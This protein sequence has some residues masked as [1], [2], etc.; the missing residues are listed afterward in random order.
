MSRGPVGGWLLLAMFVSMAW[1]SWS[2]PWESISA[3]DRY[4]AT[5]GGHG[6]TGPNVGEQP[7]ATQL[8]TTTT[9]PAQKTLPE[10]TLWESLLLNL[11]IQRHPQ[12]QKLRQ[13]KPIKT[14]TMT[15]V[16]IMNGL[17]AGQSIPFL[18]A[19][20][21]TLLARQI[22]SV[23]SSGVAISGT[24]IQTVLRRWSS[25]KEG[26]Y[27]RQL[28]WEVRVVLARLKAGENPE[29]V[30]LQLD[31][32]VG[33]EASQEFTRLW[34]SVHSED[35]QDAGRERPPIIIQPL[36]DDDLP[37]GA[38]DAPQDDAWYNLDNL[39]PD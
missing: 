5:S 32:L 19:A 11:A 18:A 7:A 24:I 38:S 21:Q 9:P 26:Q 17:G 8:L 14:F 31:S 3:E 35:K 12:L 27:M 15:N 23:V 22:L 1:P 33:V 10:N 13:E 4:L 28:E 6:V 37:N 25:K 16:A 30:R 2:E 29:L 34:K 39:N 36:A 20:E